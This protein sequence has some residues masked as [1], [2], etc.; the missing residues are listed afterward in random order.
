MHLVE[1]L[2]NVPWP[3]AALCETMAGKSLELIEQAAP[4]SASAGRLGNGVV[5]R[6]VVKVMAAVGEPMTV[7]DVQAAV[8]RLLGHTVSRDSVACCLASGA[9]TST[10]R[11]ERVARGLYRLRCR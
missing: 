2:S 5:Q 4:E 8:E 10:S 11:F 6:A 1:Q 3:L 9:R 7:A